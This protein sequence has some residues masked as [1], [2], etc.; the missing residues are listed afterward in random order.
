M[1]HRSPVRFRRSPGMAAL[2][3]RQRGGSINQLRPYLN[4]SDSDF[5]LY[6]SALADALRPN[7]P[8]PILYFA[9]EE[10]AAKST[11]ATIF[12]GLVDPSNLP[13]RTLP[14]TVRDLFVNI[15]GAQVLGFDNVSAISPAISDALCQIATG[16]GIGLRKLFT[17]TDLV[18]IGGSRSL[19]LNGLAN[20]ITRSDLADRAVIMQL[21]KIAPGKQR[22]EL[23]F[24]RA[25]E[26]ERSQIFAALLDIVAQGLSRLPRMRLSR[27]PRMADF[28]LWVSPVK[29]LMP[30][31]VSSLPHTKRMRRKPSIV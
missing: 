29:P 15:N 21:N 26:A 17:D 23:E 3:L 5:V 13:L 14:G 22:G 2:P 6:V 30:N 20:A 9:G 11:A 25:L 1:I 31:P 27:L 12:R 19:V 4:L 10:G 8:H 18:M 16:S 24:N 28:A 7:V